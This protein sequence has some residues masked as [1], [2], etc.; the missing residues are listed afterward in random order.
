MCILGDCSN[1]PISGVPLEKVC[2]CVGSCPCQLIAAKYL[3]LINNPTFS[4]S[5]WLMTWQMQMLL[6]GAL[7]SGFANLEIA[8]LR[9]CMFVLF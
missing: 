5:M 3:S 8:N 2:L 7:Y 1:T 6:I 4:A 9:F